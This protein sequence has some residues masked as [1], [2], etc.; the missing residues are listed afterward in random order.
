MAHLPKGKGVFLPPFKA[1]LASNIPAVYDNTMTY[2]EELCALIKYLQDVVIPA[3]NHNA[4]AVTTIATAVEQLQKYVEDYFKNLDVQE[5][6]NNKLDEMADDGTLQEIIGAYLDASAVWGFDN[7]ADMKASTNLINGSYAQTL[8]YYAKNDGGEGLYKIRTITNEDSVNGGTIIAMDDVSLVAELIVEDNQ[9]NIKQ[10]GAKAEEGEDATTYIQTALNSGYN[11]IIPEGTFYVSDTLVVGTQGISV[12]GCGKNSVIRLIEGSSV[13][14]NAIIK[15][16]TSKVTISDLTIY[17][18]M[19]AGD[20]ELTA[21]LLVDNGSDSCIFENI[22]L[23]RIK[24]N[25]LRT[26]FH[27]YDCQFI[28]ITGQYASLN[29]CIIGSTDNFFNKCIFYMVNLHGFLVYRGNNLF[30][31]CKTYFTGLA[32]RGVAEAD[33][34]QTGCGYYVRSGVEGSAH[35]NRF[36]NCEAQECGWHGW[37]IQGCT[38]T[39]A[40]D[41]QADTNGVYLHDSAGFVIYQSYYSKINGVV[42]NKQGI[43]GIDTPKN[44]Q[45][46]YGVIVDGEYNDINVNVTLIKPSSGSSYTSTKFFKKF[47]DIE[48]RTSNSAII[49][50][51]NYFINKFS[52]EMIEDTDGDGVA[53]GFTF[54]KFGTHVDGEAVIDIAERCQK[55]TF[56]DT[57][58]ASSGNN[59][60][61]IKRIDVQSGYTKFSMAM[62]RKEILTN[63]TDASL[64]VRFR[65]YDSDDTKIYENSRNVSEFVYEDNPN[66]RLSW[67]P[68]YYRWNI[69]ENTS[70]IT[71]EIVEILETVGTLSSA[72][73]KDF[74]YILS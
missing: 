46:D 35:T 31:Q 49:N 68:F 52:Q 55:L 60:R 19:E 34:T 26:Y 64:S 65:C 70:Y 24:G 54:D 74:N 71:F 27:T 45:H 30:N 10:F 53:D 42:T 14:G 72:C 67:T 69:A 40:V 73:I 1:W 2:Y 9:V 11:V 50:G 4:E 57:D 7:V 28:N 47:A 48:Y 61:L 17:G 8:G 15:T 33:R 6:I 59:I 12:K 13:T 62:L 66:H 51:F 36:V 18:S 22:D 23:F 3:L 29:G 43:G 21:G 44:G 37:Y 16:T 38:G 25:F 56:T 5:E 20:T 41:C 58:T 32:N 63:L 39:Q